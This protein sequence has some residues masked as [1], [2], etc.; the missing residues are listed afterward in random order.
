M[1]YF[2][3][4]FSMSRWTSAIWEETEGEEVPIYTEFMLV[5]RY[6]CIVRTWGT[7]RDQA[8]IRGAVSRGWDG[9]WVGGGHGG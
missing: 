1:E 8:E 5:Y 6:V 2:S 4:D 9:G 7:Y 3:P